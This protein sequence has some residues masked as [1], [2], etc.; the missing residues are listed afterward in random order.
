MTENMPVFQTPRELSV[1]GSGTV[2]LSPDI[3]WINIG[4]QSESPDVAEALE[5]NNARAQAIIQSLKDLGVDRKDIQTRNF[6][7]YP[8]QKPRPPMPID[9]Y[10]Q[11][12][13]QPV[14]EIEAEEPQPFRVENTLRV[15]VR[16]LDSL[17][18]ILTAV[19]QDGANLILGVAFDVEDRQAAQ[20]KA[21]DLAIADARAQAAAIAE[22]SGVKLEAIN[23][24]RMNGHS[25]FPY[26]A[27]PA[28]MAASPSPRRQVPIESG[29]LTIRATAHLTYKIA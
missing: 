17:G 18:E 27:A 22:A 14:P 28:M 10:H 3:A 15:I 13:Q 24:I 20:D 21:R 11:Q 2:E 1:S 4:V 29:Q 25:P 19:V 26:T 23:S 6:N 8:Y 7:I 12:N 16:N 9:A 5:E